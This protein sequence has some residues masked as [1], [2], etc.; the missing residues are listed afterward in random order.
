M[1]TRRFGRTEISMPVF[2]CGGM[3]YQQ[4]WD[5]L[6]LDVVEDENQKNLEATIHRSIELGINHI[7]T[8]RGYGTSERQLGLVLPQ[9][10]RDEI[11]VQTK[12]APEADPEVFR[13]HCL[14]SLERLRL[15][16]I[17]LLGLHGI[18]NYELHWQSI[19]PGGCLDVAR[20]LK[21]EGLVGHVGFSTHGDLPQILSTIE[22]DRFDYVNLHWYYIYQQN[23]A[24]VEAATKRDMG[25]FII[26]PADKGGML[27]R[28]ADKLSELCHPLHPLVFNC[29]FCLRRSE[30]H[31]LSLGA[32]CP[33]DF[34]LQVSSLDYVDLIDELLPEIDARLA[35]AVNEATGG[36]IT[37]GTA[38][39]GWQLWPWQQNLPDWE[40]SPGY[41]NIR[42]M[43]WLRILVLAFDMHEYG[44]MRYNLLGNGGHWFAGLNAANLDRLDAEKL[45]KAVAKSPHAAKIPDWLREVHGLLGGVEVERLSK[46]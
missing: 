34:D 18:N 15:D 25:V 27:Y 12:I 35:D 41:M 17:D 6:G 24:A 31:T 44:I 36:A 2:S 13:R 5:D 8:A 30:I 38:A 3:R 28:P 29:L 9:L 4:S 26:S 42:I 1:L 45:A 39:S 37:F 32:S 11:I 23:W 19:R 16:R 43:L 46:S 14:E 21:A 7:E 10:P 33:S 22:T 20:E 40:N